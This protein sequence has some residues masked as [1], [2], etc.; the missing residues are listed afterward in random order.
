MSLAK[1][2]L[3]NYTVEDYQQWKGDWELIEGIPYAMTPSP[4]EVHQKV[5]ANFIS[6]IQPQVK[7]CKQTVFVYSELDWI[8]NENTVVRTDLMIVGCE[9]IPDS[10][11]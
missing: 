9:R 6:Q 10:G 1:K 7:Q 11:P 8:V 2:Y 4:F 3:P 5:V